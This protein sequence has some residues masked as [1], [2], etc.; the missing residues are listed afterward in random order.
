ME[1]GFLWNL[2]TAAS[3]GHTKLS[4]PRKRYPPKLPRPEGSRQMTKVDFAITLEKKVLSLKLLI[5][6]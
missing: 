2:R 3:A 4:S 5:I 6:L 1:I